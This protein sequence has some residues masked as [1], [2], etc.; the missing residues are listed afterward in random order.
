MC[1]LRDVDTR[2]VGVER[3]FLG[4][5]PLWCLISW[6]RRLI[7]HR[8]VC[9]HADQAFG[10]QRQTPKMLMPSKT[11]FWIRELVLK[12]PI[13][14]PRYRSNNEDRKAEHHGAGRPVRCHQE[15]R[16]DRKDGSS[17]AEQRQQVH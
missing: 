15:R 9:R 10:S 17:R 5:S 3:L 8:N 6:S 13:D 12:P 14:D 2:N 11:M 16:N 4:H 1:P 7:E